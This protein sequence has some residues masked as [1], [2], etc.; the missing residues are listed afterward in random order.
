V[1]T[2]DGFG[3]VFFIVKEKPRVLIPAIFGVVVVGI[4]NF[5][6]FGYFGMLKLSVTWMPFA[7]TVFKWSLIFTLSA[8][9]ALLIAYDDPKVEKIFSKSF[10]SLFTLSTFMAFF[11]VWGLDLYVIPGFFVLFLME[12]A[13]CHMILS[14]STDSLEAFKGN[15]RF[16]LEDSHVIHTIVSLFILV[17]LFAIP[18]VGEYLAAFFYVLWIPNIYVSEKRRMENEEEVNIW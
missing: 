7:L 4:M 17:T 12:Y 9:S 14:G 15:M 8:W 10:V 3:D 16:I 1:K 11:V 2:L 18:Y 6:I 13:P 5:V